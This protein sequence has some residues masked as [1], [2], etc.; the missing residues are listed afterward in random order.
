MVQTRKAAFG[1]VTLIAALVASFPPSTVDGA[2]AVHIEKIGPGGGVNF[3]ATSA[4]DK[5]GTNADPVNEHG[6]QSVEF[7]HLTSRCCF[8]AEDMGFEPTTHCWASDFESDRWPI[9]LSSVARYR[10]GGTG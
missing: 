1:L 9:R 8:E 3:I 4:R 2:I 10:R 6:S 7:Q 5:T